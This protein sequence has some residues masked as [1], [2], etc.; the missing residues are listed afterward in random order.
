M[1]TRMS[2][3]AVHIMMTLKH[4]TGMVQQWYSDLRSFGTPNPVRPSDIRKFH[5]LRSH[6]SFPNPL[7]RVR[8]SGVNS[9]P[10]RSRSAWSIQPERTWSR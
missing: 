4:M 1:P 3:N 2:D 9:N 5:D 10:S 8:F 7:C 6:Y